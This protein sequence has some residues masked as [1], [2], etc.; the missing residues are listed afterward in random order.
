MMRPG[1]SELISS[2]RLRRAAE[3]F[4]SFSWAEGRVSAWLKISSVGPAEFSPEAGAKPYRV[5]RW[6]SECSP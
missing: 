6:R 2:V 5:S 1:R 4:A 3:Q